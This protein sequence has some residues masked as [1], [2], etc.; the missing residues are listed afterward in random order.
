MSTDPRVALQSLVSALE[1]HLAALSNRRSD[2][3]PAVDSAYVAIADAFDVYEEALYDNFDEVTPLTVFAE[4]D[5]D[6][7][8]EDLDEDDDD[9]SL[10]DEDDYDDLDDQDSEDSDDDSDDSRGNLSAQL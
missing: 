2:Q 1:E 3:D 8:F 9:T 10:L 4:D 7:A 5:E 6:S